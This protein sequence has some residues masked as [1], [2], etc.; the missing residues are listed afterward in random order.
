MEPREPTVRPLSPEGYDG[1]PYR[2][3][4]DRFAQRTAQI[5]LTNVCRKV[6]HPNPNIGYGWSQ[7][8][9]DRLVAEYRIFFAMHAAFPD[10][11]LPP[12]RVMDLLWHEHILDTQAYFADCDFVAGQYL[13]HMPYFGMRNAEDAALVVEA[14][15][16]E[17]D[18]YVACTGREPPPDLWIVGFTVERMNALVAG[19]F[20][21]PDAT[22]IALAE[23]APG[24]P[25]SSPGSPET[26][27]GSPE[28]ASTAEPST[29]SNPVA[30]PV[31]SEA[32]DIPEELQRAAAAAAAQLLADE[33]APILLVGN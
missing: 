2:Q 22:E 14:L 32:V 5:D 7:Q 19:R 20:T 11:A 30:E 27:M 8:F 21:D 33:D 24:S 16:V 25:R 13:H 29:L 1:E 6:M 12:S 28:A 3:R 26:S 9:T 17:H 31:A 10:V 18:L 15:N 4:F 23:A